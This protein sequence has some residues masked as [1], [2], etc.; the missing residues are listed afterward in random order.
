MS[1]TQVQSDLITDGSISAVKLH[2]TAITDKLGYTPMN[3]AGDII[4]GALIPV[5]N[6]THDLGS[7]TLAW[8]NIYTND[9]HLSNE[10]HEEGNSVDG[11]KGNWTIQEGQSD[12]YIINNKSGKK[13]KFSLEEIK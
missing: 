7:S 9:L 5:A 13:Y 11:S 1:L 3:K 4:E 2:T 10:G 12:L 6:A 8:R